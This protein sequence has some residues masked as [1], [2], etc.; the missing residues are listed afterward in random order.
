MS[1]L[2]LKAAA[3]LGPSCIQD[4][5]DTFK[6]NK[7]FLK[8]NPANFMMTLKSF[9]WNPGGEKKKRYEQRFKY[10]KG[11]KPPQKM[12][13]P[14]TRNGLTVS[15]F[16][17]EANPCFTRRQVIHSVDPLVPHSE[18]KREKLSRRATFQPHNGS[19]D[20]LPQHIGEEQP[21]T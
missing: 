10:P 4:T 17:Y 16:H 5:K 18:F 15:G 11:E 20:N 6:H 21:K 7:L 13:L 8:I 3:S 19:H 2:Y 1:S 9:I 12:M 14:N